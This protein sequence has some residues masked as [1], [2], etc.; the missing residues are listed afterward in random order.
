MMNIKA[1]ISSLA[2][3]LLAILFGVSI[4]L[5]SCSP[6]TSP[7]VSSDS[8][9]D[10]TLLNDAA[11]SSD[12]TLKDNKDFITV[13]L[14][15]NS[16]DPSYFG[17]RSWVAYNL[18]EKDFV[19]DSPWDASKLDIIKSDS[20]ESMA[21]YQLIYDK[22]SLENSLD[23]SAEM[24]GDIYGFTVSGSVEYA[25]STQ[26]SSESTSV[27]VMM[28]HKVKS[29]TL[30]LSAS[31]LI[32]MLK[33]EALQLAK[34]N[35]EKFFEKYGTHF[36]SLQQYACYAELNGKYT[37]ESQ[38]QNEE[39]KAAVDAQIPGGGFTPEVS[40]SIGV[41]A[42][43]VSEKSTFNALLKG[44]T[45][46]IAPKDP[47][48]L[49]SWSEALVT[50]FNKACIA[51]K[52]SIEVR[53]IQIRSWA[54]VLKSMPNAADLNAGNIA[55][56][57]KAA[58]LKQLTYQGYQNIAAYYNRRGFAKAGQPQWT[59]SLGHTCGWNRDGPYTIKGPQGK[60]ASDLMAVAT[61]ISR[62]GWANGNDTAH[63]SAAEAVMYYFGKMADAYAEYVQVANEFIPSVHTE[64][65][66]MK[67]LSKAVG[68]QLNQRYVLDVFKK[69][70]KVEDGYVNVCLQRTVREQ[71]IIDGCS[72]NIT[73][74]DVIPVNAQK[75]FAPIVSIPVKNT[76]GDYSKI[77]VTG[78]KSIEYEGSFYEQKE[79]VCSLVDTQL[80]AEKKYSSHCEASAVWCTQG[81]YGAICSTNEYRYPN[82]Y[83]VYG[84]LGDTD[85]D[86]EEY[87]YPGCSK[88]LL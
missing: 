82:I 53:K 58:L 80:S 32:P 71:S 84:I 49:A 75:V 50:G 68:D 8:S 28:R 83:I 27:S 85:G 86:Y 78:P 12:I 87:G 18:F 48:S 51:H 41:K 59:D 19:L 24:V 81:Y 23:I 60:T 45:F 1:Q 9:T 61:K 21:R 46:E 22:K 36:I 33:D 14:D 31:E 56:L 13:A 39:F 17:P 37:F 77:K 29:L 4:E 42:K 30:P 65:R 79:I 25:R 16:P 72:A 66:G 55:I 5:A 38:E 62:Q 76:P 54:S 63:G 47:S 74:N 35:P 69:P 73:H 7:L 70:S 40:A 26:T 44:D 34:E 88:K 43:D 10:S 67:P 52:D 3:L 2:F 64:F 20:S 15:R 11:L 57:Q 6:E